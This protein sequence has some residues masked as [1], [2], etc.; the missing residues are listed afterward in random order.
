MN[1]KANRVRTMD[2]CMGGRQGTTIK[3]RPECK[4]SACITKEEGA[5]IT[6]RLGCT[7]K[8]FSETVE[9][10]RSTVNK[11]LNG[12][13]IDKEYASKIVEELDMRGISVNPDAASFHILNSSF[14][15]TNTSVDCTPQKNISLSIN[16]SDP[17]A[18]IE[19]IRTILHQ[20]QSTGEDK[21]RVEII[22]GGSVKLTIKTTENAV[23]KILDKYI[24]NGFIF[25]EAGWIEDIVRIGTSR[26][27]ITLS[28]DVSESELQSLKNTFEGITLDDSEQGNTQKRNLVLAV[29][30]YE[31]SL[32]NLEEV[33]LSG[34]NLRATNLR[35]A[36]LRNASLNNA[37]LNNAD[38]RSAN[39]I[40]ADLRGA[41]LVG[42]KLN[43]ALLSHATDL[44]GANL[45]AADLRGANLWGANLTDADLRSANMVGT[46]L[47]EAD[48]RGANL[49]G[50]NLIGAKLDAVNLRSANLLGACFGNSL[51]RASLFGSNL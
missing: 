34:T 41:K 36:N 42:A 5:S 51:R 3:N 30:A 37:D 14:N 7:H 20:L 38:L 40:G 24:C 9:M 26:L 16:L 50:A 18:E 45:R 22:H 10:S 23:Q 12:K 27:E 31:A 19:I 48:L 44:R 13:C 39:L 4:R 6:R 43:N 29:Q 17:D 33:D 8:A 28:I 35:T 15:T 32:S 25:P 11:F 21:A 46:T 2:L 47:S 1:K 49:W